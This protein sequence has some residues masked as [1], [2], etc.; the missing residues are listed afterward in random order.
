MSFIDE[1]RSISSDDSD[2]NERTSLGCH[3][4]KKKKKKKKSKVNKGDYSS[5]STDDDYS[6]SLSSTSTEYS[7]SPS[8]SSYSNDES[9]SSMESSVESSSLSSDDSPPVVRK[10]HLLSSFNAP[11]QPKEYPALSSIRQTTTTTKSALPKMVPIEEFLNAQHSK[12]QSFIESEATKLKLPKLIPLEASTSPSVP[13]VVITKAPLTWNM[14]EHF[15]SVHQDTFKTRFSTALNTEAIL[16]AGVYNEE[17][18][19]LACH[20]EGSVTQCNYTYLKKRE[21]EYTALLEAHH[22]MKKIHGTDGVIVIVPPKNK[23]ERMR[24]HLTQDG[25][26]RV[27]ARDKRELKNLILL[28]RGEK[29]GTFMD[30]LNGDSVP[31]LQKGDGGKYEY[32]GLS[33]TKHSGAPKTI[34]YVV[35]GELSPSSKDTFQMKTMTLTPL[36]KM[37]TNNKNSSIALSFFSINGTVMNHSYSHQAK[38]TIADSSPSEVILKQ[39]SVLNIYNR[40]KENNIDGVERGLEMDIGDCIKNIHTFKGDGSSSLFNEYRLQELNKRVPVLTKEDFSKSLFELVVDHPLQKD[41]AFTVLFNMSQLKAGSSTGSFVLLSESSQKPIAVFKFN[42]NDELTS[43]NLNT[44]QLNKM[45]DCLTGRVIADSPTTIAFKDRESQYTSMKSFESDLLSLDANRVGK[46][47]KRRILRK[48]GFGQLEKSDWFPIFTDGAKTRISESMLIQTAPLTSGGSDLNL[49][50][51]KRIPSAYRAEVSLISKGTDFLVVYEF[52]KQPLAKEALL[53]M[54]FPAYKSKKRSFD[55]EN[56]LILDIKLPVIKNGAVAASEFVPKSIPIGAGQEKRSKSLLAGAMLD[57]ESHC[58]RTTTDHGGRRVVYVVF[59]ADNLTHLIVTSDDNLLYKVKSSSQSAP[60]RS[61]TLGLPKLVPLESSFTEKPTLL[62][63][64]PKLVPLGSSNST[65]TLLKGLPKLVPLGACST[66]T[67][68]TTTTTDTTIEDKKLACLIVKEVNALNNLTSK[69]SN[70]EELFE[71]R[72]DNIASHLKQYG[73]DTDIQHIESQVL[74]VLKELTRRVLELAKVSNVELKHAQENPL[75]SLCEFDKITFKEFIR[76]SESVLKSITDT[77]CAFG[78]K[79]NSEAAESNKR[80]EKVVRSVLRALSYINMSEQQK[81]QCLK[82]LNT[83]ASYLMKGLY[84]VNSYHKETFNIPLKS[85]MTTT[86]D[87]TERV[88]FLQMV[89]KRGFAQYTQQWNSLF[90]ACK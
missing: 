25:A 6:L 90:N 13:T 38:T 79:S 22:L 85:T 55:N 41:Y 34:L 73:L 4:D 32:N 60:L 84:T 87:I 74:G 26:H 24:L 20:S 46:F 43:L 88:D 8:S 9:F 45:D 48:K 78:S 77:V 66:T 31:I 23:I 80:F 83:I 2:Y 42:E 19:P 35:S 7:T 63:G 44:H 53:N 39:F 86:N 50:L 70:S 11:I 89:D 56:G 81:T 40:Y 16:N 27:I 71:I 28:P 18:I 82:S 30:T 59:D 57:E 67:T 64:L 29:C 37:V 5:I 76:P 3:L 15:N 69:K 14:K 51:K 1:C 49:K 65:T 12:Y 75:S 47:F 54:V 21:P 33:L 36:T 68:S 52:K 62:K 58:F 61:T 10:L 17:S 72:M